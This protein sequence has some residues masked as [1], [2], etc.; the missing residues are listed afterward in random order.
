MGL[1]FQTLVFERNKVSVVVRRM[2]YWDIKGACMRLWMDPVSVVVRRMYYWDAG[3]PR[4]TSPVESVSV[5]VRRM[6]Y[7]DSSNQTKNQQRT[8]FSSC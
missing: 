8:G 1:I 2:Y 7:W 6:Y 4:A 5:V 3:C